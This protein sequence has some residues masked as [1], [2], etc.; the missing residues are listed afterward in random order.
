MQTNTIVVDSFLEDPDQLRN[1][2][3][4]L[5]YYDSDKYKGYRAFAPLKLPEIETKLKKILGFD[6]D[7]VGASFL[8]HWT[9]AGTPE[10]AHSDPCPPLGEY[11][12]VLYLTP[13]APIESGTSIYRHKATLHRYGDPCH[14]EDAPAPYRY[15]DMTKYEEVDYVGNV[16]NRL[17]LFNGDQLHSMRR[18]FGYDKYTGRLTQL[19]FLSERKPKPETKNV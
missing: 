6:I 16:Y 9:P 11:G 10:V 17:I 12:G 4:M 14:Y 19:F 18:P 3:L 7:F 13:N 5:D 8:T 1:A 2:A 15:I